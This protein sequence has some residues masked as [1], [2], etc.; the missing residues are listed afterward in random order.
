MAAPVPTTTNG[1]DVY[2][3]DPNHFRPL[4]IAKL[5][6]VYQTLATTDAI[7][8]ARVNDYEM[9]ATAAA[10]LLSILHSVLR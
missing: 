3:F 8:G 10:T 6:D 4:T 2:T 9:F 5:Q 7:G 1:D